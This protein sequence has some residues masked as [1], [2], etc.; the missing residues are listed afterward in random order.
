MKKWLKKQWNE[1]K[2]D[3]GHHDWMESFH[4]LDDTVE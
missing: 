3:F 1:I 2:C 4:R